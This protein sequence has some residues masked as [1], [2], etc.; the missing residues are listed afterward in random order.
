GSYAV[1]IAKAYGATVT[2]VCSTRKKTHARELGA[3]QVIDYTTTDFSTSATRY[4]RIFDT[5]AKFPKANYANLLAPHGSYVTI[6]RL[7]S[8]ESMENLL[9]IKELIEAGKL[10]AVIDRRYPL[11]QMAEAHRYVDA[12]HKKGNVVIT[13]GEKTVAEKAV[14]RNHDR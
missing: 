12:G 5:V 7:D 14:G 6:A 4:D 3:D 2:A 1:Q 10:K 9:F 13:V 8:K 11:E